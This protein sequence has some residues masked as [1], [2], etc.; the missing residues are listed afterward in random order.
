MIL[1]S[2]I[3]RHSAMLAALALVLAA[4]GGAGAGGDQPTT[5]SSSTTSTNPPI[6]TSTTI[7][8]GDD[9]ELPAG[10]AQLDGVWETDFSTRSI[11]LEELALGIPALDPRDL[12]R[13]IDDPAFE[14]VES[15][16][17]W[18]ESTEPGVLVELDGD[19]RF[20]PLRILTRHEIVNDVVGDV[21]IAVT[22]CPLCNTAL[23]FDRTVDDRVYRFGVSGLLRNSDLVM[24]DDRTQSLWQQIT[25]EAIVGELTGTRLRQIGS[26]IVR[27][28][29][30]SDAHPEGDVLGLDQGFGIPY[31]ANP[32]VGYSSRE[33]P[34]PFFEGEI[35]DRYPALQR[36][37]GV[38]IDG[39][40][41]AYPF[42]EI[43]PLGAVNDEVGGVP[44]TV[45][46]GAPDTADALDAGFI[47]AGDGIGTGIAYLSTVDGQ[48]LILEPV[49]DDLFRD[50][51]TASTW[52]LLGEAIDGPLEGSRLQLATHRN[53]F[54]F[55]WQ[56]FFPD[57]D[58]FD[59]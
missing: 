50:T 59:R 43:A 38:T 53:E 17:D 58:V 8:R 56:A 52:T 4:C 39:T 16:A 10:I 30:F 3:R 5:V 32:Y 37:V 41:K 49:G 15:A 55:A 34:F 9:S 6:A 25:G 26:A 36:V 21:S 42:S 2:S 19:A 18:L 27:W 13:P 14:S 11:D 7:V 51:E 35:D 22:Y 24:W 29:D 57:A 23:V 1:T 33:R 54:W 40:S 44:I 28:A 48:V 47:P 45:L 31:G 46:W 12:I 20:Y